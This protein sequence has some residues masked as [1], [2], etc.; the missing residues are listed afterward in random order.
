MDSAGDD[1][2]CRYIELAVAD[3]EFAGVIRIAC[4]RVAGLGYRYVVFFKRDFVVKSD[5][6]GQIFCCAG[7]YRNGAGLAL[8]NISGCVGYRDINAVDGACACVSDFDSER[9]IPTGDNAFFVIVDRIHRYI[10]PVTD[11]CISKLALVV[12]II[13]GYRYIT[14]CHDRKGLTVNR[15]RRE[16]VDILILICVFDRLAIF[17]A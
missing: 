7:C 1:R 16:G 3:L 17:A 2:R 11:Q 9:Q 12:N 5:F 6:N 4:I 15:C 13:L 8:Y 10:V 14:S